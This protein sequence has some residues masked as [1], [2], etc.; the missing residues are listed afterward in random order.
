M[1]GKRNRVVITGA[2]GFVGAKTA[3]A[4]RAAG[5]STTLVGRRPMNDAD[6]IRQDLAEPLSPLLEERIA[7]SEL[8]LHAAARSSPWGSRRDFKRDN[9]DATRNVLEAARRNGHPRFF[10]ISSSSVYYR[11]EDQLGIEETTPYASTPVNLYAA[12]KQEA[13]LLVKG[14]EGPWAIFRPRA[15]FGPGDTV[16][17]P[18]ILQAA[19]AGKLP[20]LVRPSGPVTGD[21]IYIENLVHYLLTAAQDRSIR[22]D[23]NLTDNNPVP[24]LDFLLSI[25]DQLDLARPSRKVSV[26]TAHYLAMTVELLYRILALRSEPP[27]TRFGVHVFAWSKTFN[28]RKALAAMG[29]PPVST[30][31]GARRFVSWIKQDNPY[32]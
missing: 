13:E 27:I 24:I 22:G 25:F 6:Y 2:S 21:V 28:V 17:F 11:S 26:H 1:E 20:L 9:V 31:E 14:Y 3:Q 12:T 18:R 5:W 30:A 10:F 8:V 4:F 29:A 15:V 23:F 32:S 16:L 7:N 19:R